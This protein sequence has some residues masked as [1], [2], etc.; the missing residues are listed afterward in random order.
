MREEVEGMA[1][2]TVNWILRIENLSNGEWRRR[3]NEVEMRNEKFRANES[4]PS[5]QKNSP[6]NR[7]TRR[8][9]KF[10]IFLSHFWRDFTLPE[11]RK[12]SR[13]HFKARN[14]TWFGTFALTISFSKASNSHICTHTMHSPKHPW[15][16]IQYWMKACQTSTI[17][18]KYSA[19]LFER[20]RKKAKEKTTSWKSHLFY[21]ARS[22]FQERSEDSFWLRRQNLLYTR[23]YEG[24]VPVATHRIRMNVP[25]TSSVGGNIS[26]LCLRSG[27]L[28]TTRFL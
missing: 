15:K 26:N 8:G 6:G 22:G 3:W 10:I 16:E 4:L 2:V 23:V 24:L 17:S 7:E 1:K 9:P 25:K 18:R 21:E 13:G 12:S 28:T 27:I 11:S 5:S 19:P 14:S 20:V